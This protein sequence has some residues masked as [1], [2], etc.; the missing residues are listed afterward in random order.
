MRNTLDRLAPLPHGVTDD[1]CG[2]PRQ[3][4]DREWERQLRLEEE[5]DRYEVSNRPPRHEEE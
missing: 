5:G 2:G 4:R 3:H 1:D